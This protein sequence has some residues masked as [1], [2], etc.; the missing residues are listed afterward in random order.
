MS[1][2][3]KQANDLRAQAAALEAQAAE[4][5]QAARAGVLAEVKATIAEYSFSAADLGLKGDKASRLALKTGR[6]HPSAGKR[7]EAKYKDS[8]GNS[9]TGRGVKPRWLTS[10]LANGVSLESFAVTSQ[11]AAA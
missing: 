1:D 7:V 11:V 5:I 6:S 8:N 3:L 9:W 2:L 10:A 4:Q